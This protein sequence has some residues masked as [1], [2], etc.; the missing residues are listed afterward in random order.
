MK[1]LSMILIACSIL[2]GCPGDNVGNKQ[3]ESKIVW[4]ILE[5]N[6]TGRWVLVDRTKVPNGWLVRWHNGYGSDMEFVRDP[7]YT[8]KLDETS[9]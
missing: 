7:N 6:N 9:R 8:W 3:I 1:K 5:T 2:I 4:E